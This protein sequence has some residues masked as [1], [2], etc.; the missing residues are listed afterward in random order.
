MHVKGNWFRNKNFASNSLTHF[1]FLYSFCMLGDRILSSNG[2]MDCSKNMTNYYSYWYTFCEWHEQNTS[3]FRAHTRY[4]SSGGDNPTLN[5]NPLRPEAVGRWTCDPY[6]EQNELHLERA[7]P[8]ISSGII[9]QN[10]P[11]RFKGKGELITLS[12]DS[13]YDPNAPKY[14]NIFVDIT[15]SFTFFVAVYFPSCTGIMAG[16]NRSG[17][18]KDPQG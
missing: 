7:V 14:G 5:F 12:E 10:L 3:N 9:K 17:D 15:T 6:F 2:S 13:S 16:S 1:I 4:L 11:I 18:L 8:G